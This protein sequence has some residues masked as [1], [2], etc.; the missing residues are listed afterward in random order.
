MLGV[1]R[2]KRAI[3]QADSQDVLLVGSNG[4]LHLLK[5][6]GDIA[7]VRVP[8]GNNKGNYIARIASIRKTGSFTLKPAGD[9][10]PFGTNYKNCQIV[11]H[12]DGYDYALG[13]AFA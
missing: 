9:S 4:G 11:H 6:I 12:S 5:P 7:R 1:A 2:P 13:E 8:K 3:L 10:K